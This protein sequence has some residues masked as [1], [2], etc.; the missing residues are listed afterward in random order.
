MALQL[1]DTLSKQPN[2][3][4]NNSNCANKKNRN[5]YKDIS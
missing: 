3:W 4:K 5:E 2:S 1:I